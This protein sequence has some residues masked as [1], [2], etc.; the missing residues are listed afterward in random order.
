MGNTPESNQQENEKKI[1]PDEPLQICGCYHSKKKE[2]WDCEDLLARE[3]R[4][5]NED[6]RYH[7]YY[8]RPD[9]N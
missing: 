7:P 4:E 8:P 9:E 2:C 1:I 5:D 3:E 6:H